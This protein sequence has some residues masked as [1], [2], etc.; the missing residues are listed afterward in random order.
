MRTILRRKFSVPAAMAL[1]AI[2]SIAG[3]ADTPKTSVKADKTEAGSKAPAKPNLGNWWEKSSLDFDTM[4]TQFLFHGTANASYMNAQGNSQGSMFNGSV[5]LTARKERYTNHFLAQHRRQ[6]MTYGFGGGSVNLTESTLKDYLDYD[7]TARTLVLAGIEDYHNSFLFI[8][9]RVTYYGGFGATPVETKQHLVNVT[10]GLGYANFKFDRTGM[11]H[12]NPVAVA[13]LP[14]ITPSSGG[15]LVTE[16]W[17]WT[18][19]DKVTL[20]QDATYMK[21]FNQVL[22]HRWDF[23]VNLN[24]PLA[25]YVSFV[26]SYRIRDEVNAI[27]NALGVKPQ[28]RTLS[29]GLS[30]SF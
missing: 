7:L 25:K 1:V 13:G 22:G 12:V 20:M 11:L 9:R 24:V 16:T 26:P 4:P 10:G 14:T 18:F 19:S 8:D 2:L 15:A 28:D 23:G 5:D 30:V 27:T 3:V 6:D 29:L 17:R 21:Y